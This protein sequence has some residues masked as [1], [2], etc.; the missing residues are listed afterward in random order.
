MKAL[1]RNLTY[2]NV[3]ATLALVFAMSGGALAAKH[4]LVNSTK[5]LN[6]RVIHSL[7]TTDTRIFLKLAKSVPMAS[8]INAE[9]ATNASHA[10]TA[11]TASSALALGSVPASG[12][13]RSDCASQTG[14]VKGFALVPAGPH[15]PEGFTS[16]ATAYNCSGRVIEARRIEGETGQYEVHFPGNPE[17]VALATAAAGGTFPSPDTV[18]VKGEGPGDWRVSVYNAQTHT[19]VDDAFELLVP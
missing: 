3:T 18:S 16:V 2:A 19:L 1:R 5:Q 4:Y 12:Y 6:P 11:S 15:F 10:E 13:T 8:A 14:Q 17:T 7:E 9:S